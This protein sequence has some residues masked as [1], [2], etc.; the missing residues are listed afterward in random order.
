MFGGSVPEY[1]L[2]AGKGLPLTLARRLSKGSWSLQQGLF[3][4]RFP[5]RMGL[6]ATP[7]P[8]CSV[9]LDE[10]PG[11]TEQ[12]RMAAFVPCHFSFASLGNGAFC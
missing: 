4:S 3:G 11:Q 8:F 5:V 2:Q 7:E 12:G 9:L 10:F 6:R 1:P